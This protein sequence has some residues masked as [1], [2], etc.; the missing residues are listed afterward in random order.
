MVINNFDM[1]S[2][3]YDSSLFRIMVE[4]VISAIEF[5]VFT[6][7]ISDAMNGIA[8]RFNGELTSAGERVELAKAQTKAL[9]KIYD[10]LCVKL[11]AKVKEFKASMD[12]IGKNV[13]ETLLT[14]INK[15]FEMLLQECENREAEIAGYQDYMSALEAEAAK[16]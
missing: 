15:E 2:E 5:P 10:E 7:D 1:G 11:A 16:L 13:Q 3:K 9:S 4:E 6:L 14:E 12:S 8:G